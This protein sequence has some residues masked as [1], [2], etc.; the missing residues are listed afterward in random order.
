MLGMH[1]TR[2]F[3]PWPAGK[4]LFLASTDVVTTKDMKT[5]LNETEIRTMVNGLKTK[6]PELTNENVQK[7]IRCSLVLQ[8]FPWSEDMERKVRYCIHINPI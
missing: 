4:T 2:P 1:Q 6:D 5:L 3:T 8:G 7:T